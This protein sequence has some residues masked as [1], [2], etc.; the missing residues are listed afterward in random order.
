VKTFSA[1]DSVGFPH[2]KVGHCQAFVLKKIPLTIFKKSSGVF[3]CLFYLK[4][5]VPALK[6]ARD[7]SKII[8]CWGR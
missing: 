7:D 4:T 3:F 1:D 2:V 6:A 5:L 8:F